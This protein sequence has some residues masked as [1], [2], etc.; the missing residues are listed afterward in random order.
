MKMR[1]ILSAL[2]GAVALW[3]VI[4]VLGFVA[5]RLGCSEIPLTGIS[6]S[7]PGAEKEEHRSQG[8]R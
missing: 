7:H 4:L 3:A 8:E 2:T 6:I 5:A 1:G